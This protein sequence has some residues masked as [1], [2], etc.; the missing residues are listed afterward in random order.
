MYYILVRQN[1]FCLSQAAFYITGTTPTQTH[2]IQSGNTC[3][4]G[5]IY[6]VDRVVRV[7]IVR[8]E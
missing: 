5:D 7:S 1:I 3:F 4:R 8:V 2:H 6:L